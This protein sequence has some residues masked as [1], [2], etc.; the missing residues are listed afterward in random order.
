MVMLQN[1]PSEFKPYS[2]QWYVDDLCFVYLTK[3]VRSLLKFFNMLTCHLQFKVKSK[4]ECPFLMYRL[5]VKIKHLPLLS[6][7]NL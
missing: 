3:I 4:T 6:T 7:V 2:C 1:C 5:F